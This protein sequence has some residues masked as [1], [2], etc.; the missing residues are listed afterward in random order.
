M[1]GRTGCFVGRRIGSWVGG[2]N[3][4]AVGDL[5]QYSGGKDDNLQIEVLIQLLNAL[6]R[7]LTAGIPGCAQPYPKETIPTWNFV[8]VK[9]SGH[10]NHLDMYPFLPVGSPRCKT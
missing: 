5:L 9:K 3:V 1:G 7:A 2:A 4:I 6:T 10:P 8:P